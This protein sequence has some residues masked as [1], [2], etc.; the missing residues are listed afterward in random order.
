MRPAGGAPIIAGPPDLRDLIEKAETVLGRAEDATRG[1]DPGRVSLMLK[2][3]DDL[4]GEF[5]AASRLEDLHGALDAA[6]R[7]ARGN[8]LAGAAAALRRARSLLP[9]LADYVVTRQAEESGRTAIAAAEGGDAPGCL[10]AIDRL[11]SSVLGT[12]LL[13]RLGEARQAIGRARA[14]MVRRD[15]ATGRAEVE[16]AR[17]AID[18]LHYCGALSRA[19]FAL[20]IGS[21]LLRDGASVAA[22][23]QV[24]RA[25]RD[26]RLAAGL[27][28]EPGRQAIEETRAG[29]LEVWR[30]I[31]R[32]LAGDSERLEEAARQ[33]ETIR[34]ALAG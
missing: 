3:A 21:E 14:A 4:I 31:N 9:A 20:R 27:A 17:R 33:V 25:S 22:R 10:R 34:T 19:L 12:V 23:D 26:L 18:G 29:V 2:R 11:E 1:K 5:Q 13:A 6:R 28:P 24:Q 30:R 32:P 15:M 16:A 8:D 7:G